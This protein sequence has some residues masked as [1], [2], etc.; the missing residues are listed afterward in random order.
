MGLNWNAENFEELW[1][2]TSKGGVVFEEQNATK[3]H[4]NIET[5]VPL[6]R[7]KSVETQERRWATFLHL[8]I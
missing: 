6:K 8:M 5:S 1:N 2:L 7:L 3:C 4:R